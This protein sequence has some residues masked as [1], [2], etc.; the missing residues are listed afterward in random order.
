MVWGDG[1]LHLNVQLDD[2]L[3]PD[4]RWTPPGRAPEPDPERAPRHTTP[5]RSARARSWSPVTTPARARGSSRRQPAGRCFAEPSSGART[6]THALRCYRL[7]LDTDLGRSIERVVVFGHPTLSRPVTRL[8]GR[9]DV[10]VLATAAPGVWSERPFA[11]TPIERPDR[12]GRRPGL[13]RA[14]AR[15]RPRRRGRPRPAARRRARPHAVRR[16]RGG[17][18]GPA[19]RGSAGGRRLEPDPRPGPDGASL[20][21]RRAAQGD[22]QPWPLRHRRHRLHGD[23]CRARPHRF[24]AGAGADGRR[25]VPPRQQRPRA[26]AGRAPSPT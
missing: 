23:R 26:R 19:A 16:G 25:D 11:A 10:E 22:R 3:V 24:V 17:Q 12:R 15:R 21:G 5:S 7:L 18:P 13:A 1:P 9:D 2:P 8:L 4:D 6:G 20:R 14:V